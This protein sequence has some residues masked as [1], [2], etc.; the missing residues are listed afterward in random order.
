MLGYM[1]FN[2]LKKRPTIGLALGGGGPKGLA[3]IGVLKVLEKNNIPVDYIAGTSAGSI[4]GSFYAAR[5]NIGEIEE[6]IIKKNWLQMLSLL[7]DPSLKG[8]LFQGRRAQMFLEGYLGKNLTFSDLKIPFKA[9]AV[10][11]SNGQAVALEKGPVVPAVLASCAIPMMF[12][13]V[14]IDGH[15]LIDGG[16]TSPVPVSV[17]RKMGA[18]IVIAVNLNK[19]YFCSCPEEGD[20]NFLSVAQHS[21]SI[22]MHNIAAY[23]TK[24]ADLLLT[25]NVDRIHWR[26]LMNEEEKIRGI[27]HGEAAM[28]EGLISLDILVKSRQPLIPAFMERLRKAFSPASAN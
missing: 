17:A 19:H 22:M 2:L 11:I 27:R 25:P 28:E 10:E 5:R 20:M 8:G 4:V 16:I 13:P 15:Y 3:H 21:L 26:T 14:R 7:S 23:E 9:V 18:D 12:K 1:K 24:E 6:Y